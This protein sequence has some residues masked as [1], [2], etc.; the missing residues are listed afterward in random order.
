[1][2]F[3]YLKR[4]MPE[5]T[6]D[7]GE[8]ADFEMPKVYEPVNHSPFNPSVIVLPKLTFFDVN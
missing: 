3:F 4:D 2:L 8:D 1:M 5:A 7:E 6:G